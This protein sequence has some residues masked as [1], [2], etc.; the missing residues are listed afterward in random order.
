MAKKIS[1]DPNGTSMKREDDN[2]S[3]INPDADNSV[4]Q[5][6]DAVGAENNGLVNLF[7]AAFIAMND[8]VKDK[9]SVIYAAI[10]TVSI[11]AVAM[12]QQTAK[13]PKENET[14]KLIAEFYGWFMKTFKNDLPVIIDMLRDIHSYKTAPVIALGDQIIDLYT[15]QFITNEF[16]SINQEDRK[17]IS[18]AAS[19]A[20]ADV[21]HIN[22]YFFGD[23]ENRFSEYYPENIRSN[24]DRYMR[25]TI[26]NLTKL[27]K[28]GGVCIY[29]KHPSRGIDIISGFKAEDQKITVLK[30]DELKN[31][32]DKRINI[33]Y[34]NGTKDMTIIYR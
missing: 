18:I 12:T 34:P 14:R 15:A 3:Y 13:T 23:K 9:L 10:E 28:E 16:K 11:Y 17:M 21:L 20:I 29:V 5:D 30:G 2:N 24:T 6:V 25:S 19:E 27:M 7:N 33:I 31:E 1:F 8:V 4:V 32:T 26:L 22:L